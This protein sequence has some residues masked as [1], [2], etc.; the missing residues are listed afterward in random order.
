M[1]TVSEKREKQ[2]MQTMRAKPNNSLSFNGSLFLI[3]SLDTLAI[4]PNSK[5]IDKNIITATVKE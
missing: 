4:Y 3:N 1:N 5:N 2:I